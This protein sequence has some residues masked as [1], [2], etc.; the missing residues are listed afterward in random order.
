MASAQPKA[1]RPLSPHL[2]IY[3]PMLTMTMS[4]LHRLTGMANYF[5]AAILAAWLA[6]AANGPASLDLANS[7]LAS[8]PGQVILFG[9][10]WSVL[11]HLLGGIRHFIWDTGRGFGLRTV[12]WMVRLSLLASVSLTLLLWACIY[13]I[14]G[15]I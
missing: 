4:I 1:A 3:R 8:L 12:E 13:Q 11:H 15:G 6:A 2:Q 5:S 10:S 7:L 14:L 9:I